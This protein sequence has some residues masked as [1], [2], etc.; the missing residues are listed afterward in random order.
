MTYSVTLSLSYLVT[1]IIHL[2]LTAD[3]TY[4]GSIYFYGYYGG[5]VAAGVSYRAAECTY[6]LHIFSRCCHIR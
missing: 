1:A 5:Y 4:Y 2:V 6:T 3:N